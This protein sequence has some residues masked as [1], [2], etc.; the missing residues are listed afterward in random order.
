M[1]PMKKPKTKKVEYINIAGVNGKVKKFDEKLH[2]KYDI[3]AR[4]VLKKTLGDSIKDNDD[5]YGEDMIFT[6][7]NFP[8]KYLEVQVFA[9]WDSEKFPYIQPFVYARKMRFS[10]STLFVTFNRYFSEIIIFGRDCL[11]EKSYRLK[12]YEKEMV[13][14][15]PW[16]S[17][18]RIHINK[19]TPE[20]IKKY[21]GVV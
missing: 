18:M 11:S 3:E 7:K 6:E 17:T 12:K 15:V 1:L 21:V 9:T 19:L 5:I 10:K 16:G 20:L 2:S 13:N 4:N 14:Y 8:F